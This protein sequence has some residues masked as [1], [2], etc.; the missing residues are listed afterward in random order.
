MKNVSG[1]TYRYLAWRPVGSSP[2]FSPPYTRR[3]KIEAQASSSDSPSYFDSSGLSDDVATCFS[4]AEYAARYDGIYVMDLHFDLEKATELGPEQP[5]ERQKLFLDR[6]AHQISLCI[7][8]E[9]HHPHYFHSRLK[10]GRPP[11]V[12]WGSRIIPSW[13]LAAL[14]AAILINYNG[15]AQEWQV[16][17]GVVFLGLLPAFGASTLMLNLMDGAHSRL[18]PDRAL[19]VAPIQLP[20]PPDASPVRELRLHSQSFLSK[21]ICLRPNGSAH[22]RLAIGQ[23]RRNVLKNHEHVSKL[24]ARIKKSDS[25]YTIWL[26][27]LFWFSFFLTIFCVAIPMVCIFMD[28]PLRL[29]ATQFGLGASIL[30]LL[31]SILAL[32]YMILCQDLPRVK[33][34]RAASGFFSACEPLN[35]IITQVMRDSGNRT[36]AV[37]VSPTFMHVVTTIETQL[38]GEAQRLQIK[39]F[40]VAAMGTALGALVAAMAIT[41]TPPANART[42]VDCT[43]SKPDENGTIF[44]KCQTLPDDLTP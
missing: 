11:T 41:F 40:W 44:Q 42:T 25:R 37:R 28:W 6:A 31:G 33:I 15:T 38:A 9:L 18:S 27:R 39:Q 22:D 16:I 5:D 8:E 4:H 34:L 1:G 29:S 30:M 19:R 14:L 26:V 13:V 3:G 43:V 36:L 24:V 32:V 12:K 23:L 17:L 2:I 35:D 21:L 10:D 7:S 20:R